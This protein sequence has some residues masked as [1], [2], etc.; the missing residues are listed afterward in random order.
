MNRIIATVL[1]SVVV[2]ALIA[3]QCIFFVNERQSAIVLQLGEAIEDKA[4]TSGLNFKLP[5]IQSVVFFE[6]RLLVFD[7]AKTETLTADLKAFEIDN[8]VCWRITDPMLFYR[9]LRNERGAERRLEEI[10]FSQLRAAIGSRELIEVVKTH[11]AAIMA[12]VLERA[13]TQA[14]Q[15]GVRIVDVRIKRADLPNRPAIY[16]RMIAER[17]RMAN[18]YRYEGQSEFLRIH[19]EAERERDVILADANRQSIII[20]GQADANAIRI[21]AEAI[22][23]DP[24]FYEFSKSLEVYRRAFRD[25]SRIILSSDDPLLRYLR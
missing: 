6:D 7:I 11:R 1:A 12:T 16:A 23:L 2:V 8:Y 10:V 9:S 25:N 20:R 17:Q 13:Q 4:R 19:S 18:L 21:F 24:E 22:S 15:Y 5:F 14:E 3:T